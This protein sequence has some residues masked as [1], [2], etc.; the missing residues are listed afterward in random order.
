M[1]IR[2]PGAAGRLL[3][4]A[5]TY[6]ACGRSRRGRQ[7]TRTALSTEPSA[8]AASAAEFAASG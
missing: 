1:T 4:Q 6:V 8:T 3:R 5:V 7:L 2:L